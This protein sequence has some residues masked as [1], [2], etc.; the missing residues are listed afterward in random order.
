M[1]MLPE[2][3]DFNEA[4]MFT[5]TALA[6]PVNPL[7]AYFRMPGLHIQ[8][9]TRGA[10]L[11][12]ET[13]DPTLAG[14]VPVLPMKASDE[15]LLRSP[16]AL[17]SG[18]AIEQLIRSC[19][20]SIQSPRMVSSPDLDVI[21]LAIR[22]ATYGP[23]ME[24]EVVCPQC[25]TDN[26]FDCNLSAMISKMTFIDPVNEVRLNNDMLV[27]VRPHNLASA[28]KIAL[29]SYEEARK[30]Q[31]ME[32][33]DPD[34]AETLN[35]SYQKMSQ[36]NLGAM[37]DAIITVITPTA[38]VTDKRFIFDFINNCSQAWVKKIDAKLSEL[39]AKGIDKHVDAVCRNCKHEWAP[40]V[41]F[42]PT[43]F[44]GQSS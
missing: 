31:S 20:P 34:R 25:A 18:Y 12:R 29:A 38:Q 39:N 16:D 26:T 5:P 33:D 2:E 6:P 22:A 17:M 32:E 4:E 3:D 14:D 30:L 8:L 27:T 28:T 36:M 7:A 43:S 19:V 9:P 41:E 37:T 11:P 21:L 1:P 24:I 15:L 40:E 42:D 13:F 35:Q 44:F 10:F 23:S